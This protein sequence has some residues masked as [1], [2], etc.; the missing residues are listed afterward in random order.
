MADSGFLLHTAALLVPELTPPVTQQPAWKGQ[1]IP[2]WRSQPARTER[3]NSSSLHSNSAFI[4]ALSAAKALQSKRKGIGE[5][6]E[7]MKERERHVSRPWKGS[8]FSKN[9]FFLF[10]FF[11]RFQKS[12]PNTQTLQYPY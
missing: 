2:Q 6:I 5:K 1:V 11:Y 9:S 7:R 10:F 3:Q 12:P 4:S 8:V